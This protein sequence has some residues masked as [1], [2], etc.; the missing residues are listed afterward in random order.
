MRLMHSWWPQ[1]SWNQACCVLPTPLA[2]GG[3]PFLADHCWRTTGGNGCALL[4]LFCMQTAKGDPAVGCTSAEWADCMERFK[5]A[6]KRAVRLGGWHA[7]HKY[8][9]TKFW[10]FDNDK[11]HQNKNLWRAL[12]I[13]KKNRYP[14]PPNSP[15]MHKVV[16]HC[17]HNLKTKFKDFLYKNPKQL[18]MAE[19]QKVLKN[20]FHKEVKAES[21]KEDV[22]TLYDTYRG[23]LRARGGQPPQQFR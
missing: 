5:E 4:P 22:D 15:D 13:Q 19:Y 8:P 6:A 3:F 10:S 21:I 23:I 16:E 18:T 20:I 9:A 11:I 7:Y 17:I 2:G 14:L 12:S 1:S